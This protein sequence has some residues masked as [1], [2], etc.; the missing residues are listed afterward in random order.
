MM[1]PPGINQ[2]NTL[3][4]KYQ[5]APLLVLLTGASGAG[6]T[7]LAKVLEGKLDAS[8]SQVAFFDDKGVPSEEEMIRDFGSGEKWQE[9]RT[10]EWISE[11]SKMKDKALVILEGSYNPE[12]A[13]R[14]CTL[15]GVENYVLVLVDCNDEVR[16]KRLREDR[17][18][19]ELADENMRGWARALRDK[20]R[21]LGG[22]VLDTSR[23]E[24]NESVDA[25]AGLVNKS[26][27]V[28]G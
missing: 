23:S 8:K 10:H 11:L 18:Q 2:T 25:F 24:L 21:E 3:L 14:A 17:K 26:L 28:R 12:F 13:K 27:R 9:A 20:T 4:S 7:S 1:A 5:G 15:A 16:E 6:K 22:E 19:P